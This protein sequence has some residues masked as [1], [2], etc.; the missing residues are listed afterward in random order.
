MLTVNTHMLTNRSLSQPK[1]RKKGT[2]KAFP[3]EMLI[4]NK[5]NRKQLGKRFSFDLPFCTSIKNRITRA[6]HMLISQTNILKDIAHTTV[7]SMAC[8]ST[9]QGL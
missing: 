3:R 1:E 9:A 2:K 5:R 7:M 6:N 4:W 8:R